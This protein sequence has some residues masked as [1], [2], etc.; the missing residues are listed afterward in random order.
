VLNYI[1]RR[2]LL[3]F[4]TLIGILTV[5]FIIVQFTPGGP[6]ENIIASLQG[7][8]G[9]GLSNLSG[10][11]DSPMM[12]EALI[13]VGTSSSYRGAAG[14]DPEFIASLEQ[15]FGFDKPLF[16]RYIS[17]LWDYLH[18]DFGT[19]YFKKDSVL[20][21]II[22]A[23]PVSLTLGLWQFLLAHAI[24]IPL[25]IRKAIGDGSPF[26]VWT[27]FIII[28]GYAIPGFLFG[29]L[30]MVFFAG[31]SFFDWFPLGG[32]VSDDFDDLSFGAKILDYL[33]HIALPVCAM[34]ISAFATTTLLTKNCFLEEI[35]KQY[36]ITARAKGCSERSVLYGH[37]FR[38]A[39]LVVIAGFPSSFIA[40]F[41]TGSLLLEMLFSLNGIGLL[42]YE[43]IISRDYP[44][45]FGALF[46]FSLVGLIVSLISDLVY[47][48]VDPRIDFERR[49]V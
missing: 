30:L 28:I 36:V 2:L 15:Q 18:F 10:G 46:I 47:M 40:A 4:P 17:M 33:W 29:V 8:G 35:R 21:L 27:S 49:D 48:L 6:I 11:S 16:I 39:M 38:N 34:V 3:I 26:D 7:I 42:S 13:S 22:N 41:F 31:G 12:G 24:S 37:V 9:D 19:S 14:L 5:T 43:A 45:V 1:I 25:G 20:Q 32:L 44:L 23:L